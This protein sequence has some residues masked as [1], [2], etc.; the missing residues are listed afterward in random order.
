MDTKQID[1]NKDYYKS[2]DVSPDATLDEINRQYE[3][4]QRL[5]QPDRIE[6]PEDR[7]YAVAKLAEI[8][9]AYAALADEKR[10][11]EAGSPVNPD[12]TNGD[13]TNA[14]EEVLYCANH[15]TVETLLRCN[16]C[17][18]PICIK[19]A[20]QTPVGYRCRECVHQ[21][22][23]VYFNAESTDNLV[24]FGVGFAVTAVAAPILGLL[25]G[26]LGFWGF[27]VAFFVG[28]GAGSLL[29]Q[30]IRRAVGRRRGRQL[31]TYA[32]IGI[33][34]GVLVGNMALSI[35]LG[36]PLL[37]F[38]FNLPMLLFTALALG[39]AYPQLR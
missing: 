30:I 10:R 24:A 6:N 20:V 9:E 1:R 5:Y 4:L 13:A 28:S 35:V 31:P 15:P 26:S 18:K 11:S 22:Q 8:Q 14:G 38:I 37:T 27:L 7:A 19:C 32:L 23:N 3:R 17:S 29:A 34:V 25:I 16:R 39:S 36:A 21:Q 12:G 2:L 33:V